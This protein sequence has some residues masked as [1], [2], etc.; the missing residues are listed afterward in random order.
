MDNAFEKEAP[1]LEQFSPVAQRGI[2]S[3]LLRA[4][5]Q[6]QDLAGLWETALSLRE[7]PNLALVWPGVRATSPIHLPELE[8][9]LDP[10]FNPDRPSS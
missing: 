3:S 10:D 1:P 7:N 5:A 8:T 6:E 4:M 2:I 9:L